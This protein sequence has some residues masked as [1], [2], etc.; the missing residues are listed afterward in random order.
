MRHFLFS[1][2]FVSG[3]FTISSNSKNLLNSDILSNNYIAAPILEDFESGSKSTYAPADV[4][5]TTG[6]WFFNNALIGTLA[7]DKMNGA[8]SVRIRNI[9]SIRMNFDQAE[10]A[11]TISIMHAVFGS[12]GPSTW[13]LQVST[14]GGS[15]FSKVGGS[16]TSSN[17]TLQTTTFTVNI[18]GTFRI[19]IVKTA[20][21]TNRINIDDIIINPLS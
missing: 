12:D 11:S 4:Q 15:S 20:G 13:E 14:D 19:A 17:S 8:K 10:G 18:S 2:F 3:V 21:G 16:I 1:L 7:S 5:L 9:G 6:I